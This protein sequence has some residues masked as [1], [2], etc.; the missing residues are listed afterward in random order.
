M[1]TPPGPLDAGPQRRHRRDSVFT[2]SALRARA[3]DSM[4]ATAM[5]A[6][7]MKMSFYYAFLRLLESWLRYDFGESIAVSKKSR[8][9]DVQDEIHNDGFEKTTYPRSI[10]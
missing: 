1:P 9:T 8:E 3:S 5:I 7:K 4:Q 10:T 2:S 6:Q